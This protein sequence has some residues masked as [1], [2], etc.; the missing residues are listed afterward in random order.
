MKHKCP[1]CH[2]TVKSPSQKQTEEVKLFPFCSERCRLIDLGAWL[3]AEY[4]VISEL[5]DNSEDTTNDRRQQDSTK[6]II[7]SIETER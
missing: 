6:N 2:K 5:A 7:K 1:I 4:K 3:D